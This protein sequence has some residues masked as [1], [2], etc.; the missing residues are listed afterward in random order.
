[1]V[2][3][4]EQILYSKVPPEYRKQLKA[5]LNQGGE[6][7]RL[8]NK[9]ISR[10]VIGQLKNANKA[11]KTYGDFIGAPKTLHSIEEAEAQIKQHPSL[12][13]TA[14]TML[15]AV[16]AGKITKFIPKAVQGEI[17]KDLPKRIKQVAA[18]PKAQQLITKYSTAISD[19]MDSG[20]KLL[21]KQTGTKFVT[22]KIEAVDKEFHNLLEYVQKINQRDAARLPKDLPA[23]RN[24]VTAIA[25][26]NGISE[27]QVKETIDPIF[28]RLMKEDLTA[29]QKAKEL[30]DA[31]VQANKKLK[32]TI[33]KAK[34]G[35]AAPGQIRLEDLDNNLYDT[36]AANEKT[37][38]KM[39]AG[40]D[41]TPEEL[42][43]LKDAI[44]ENSGAFEQ[45]AQDC[46]VKKGELTKFIEFIKNFG[47]TV[48]NSPEGI[49]AA[50]KGEDLAA[51]MNDVGLKLVDI[52][53]TVKAHPRISVA[54]IL[55]AGGLGT[56]LAHN[57][58][59]LDNT[60]LG[61]ASRRKVGID[62]GTGYT[63]EQQEEVR[64]GLR[65]RGLQDLFKG[66]QSLTG[67][68]GKR[69]HIKGDRIY[70]YSTGKPVNINMAIDDIGAYTDKQVAA[71]QPERESLSNQLQDLYQA[72]YE[73]YDVAPQ[74]DLTQQ[75]LNQL[76]NDLGTLP[77]IASIKASRQ[78]SY[79]VDSDE[80]LVDQ[81]KRQV[82]EPEQK[83]QQEQQAQQQATAKQQYD[84]MYADAFNRIADATYRDVEKYYTPENLSM[85]YMNFMMEAAENKHGAMTP[86]QY[87]NARKM[88]AMHE[89]A[90]KISEKAFSSLNTILNYQQN[91]QQLGV[92]NAYNQGRLAETYRH[93]LA[94]EAQDAQ[95]LN[96][97]INKQA[98]DY[99][100]RAQEI[101]IKQH[102]N[103]ISAMNADTSRLRAEI[104][105][106]EHER[107]A[108]LL[109]YQ[110]M[111]SLG[112]F[113]GNMGM[114]GMKPSQ[115]APL[116]PDLFGS[117]FPG[118][119]DQRQSKIDKITGNQ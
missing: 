25:K 9:Y 12:T 17:V 49:K 57:L 51:N 21:T 90:Q 103:V 26:R 106:Q 99:S 95:D 35:G 62:E 32:E 4:I 69:Y 11:L 42:K 100:Q 54:T 44:K 67:I 53:N 98:Q 111:E 48:E 47:K 78:E 39:A 73:G 79:N 88:Q 104:E 19:A 55:S 52:W 14:L 58:G 63:P 18:N 87:A 31:V 28:E 13:D 84:M 23:I 10:F 46:K 5:M 76:N 15:A 45:L 22:G 27:V 102:G 50:A 109:P 56:L 101:G 38:D 92:T 80:S 43:S 34:S 119:V 20:S 72:Q 64:L 91:Q 40:R 37:I 8:A 3:N 68:S 81:Y 93:N 65:E 97:K 2:K 82:L 61:R 66:E 86:Q 24:E 117:V 1:M 85:D 107:K 94:G 30:H 118:T 83:A 59:Y 41:V 74:I 96:F 71:T 16:P 110:Q 105:Q 75:R 33:T 70:D 108:K 77:D 89:N 115:V 29:E 116:N 36:L 60:P 7:A 114:S 112:S 113:Y 6:A